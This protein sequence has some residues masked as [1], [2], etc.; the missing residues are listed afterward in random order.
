L[1]LV[2][3]IK[4]FAGV[5][6]FIQQ[7]QSCNIYKIVVPNIQLTCSLPDLGVS[8]HTQL[9]NLTKQTDTQTDTQ[10]VKD[11]NIKLL[12]ATNTIINNAINTIPIDNST[13][14][15]NNINLIKEQEN[16]C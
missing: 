7:S 2:E 9:P 8:S 16:Q 11:N 14:N 12:T 1:K 10:T 3:Q 15:D 4:E 6:V 13:I 5:D